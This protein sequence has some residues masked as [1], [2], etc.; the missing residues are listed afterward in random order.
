[1]E[2]RLLLCRTTGGKEAPVLIWAAI[3]AIAASAQ[4]VILAGAAWYASRQVREA[5]NDRRVNIMLSLRDY[6]DS[7]ESRQ[8]RYVLFNDLP[9]DLTSE[10][11]AE[12]DKVIDRVVVEYESIGSLVVKG[13]INFDLMADLY[14]NSAE[15]SWKRVKPWVQKERARRNN[16]T[17]LPNFE[18][19]AKEC[20]EYN[21]R[22][23]GEE[24]QTFRRAAKLPRSQRMISWRRGDR[25]PRQLD[26]I[27]SQPGTILS[28]PCDRPS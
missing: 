19:F 16:A 26:R 7:P 23:H 15:R 28:T 14:G 11:T 21:A 5:R 12:Q 22:K 18:K 4:T 13:F 24:L 25:G 9:D 20:I 1:M 27:P 3:A 6:I 2:R 17:F 8:N 10:L